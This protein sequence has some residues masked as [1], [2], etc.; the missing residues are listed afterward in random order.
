ML[1][2]YLGLVVSSTNFGVEGGNV[3]H[4]R[5][6][7][8]IINHVLFIK[9][10]VLI[11]TY[12]KF[13]QDVSSDYTILYHLISFS[14][15]TTKTFITES[16]CV[17]THILEGTLALRTSSLI[18]TFPPSDDPCHGFKFRYIKYLRPNVNAGIHA[19]NQAT[20]AKICIF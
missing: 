11:N 9:M 14:A 17:S 3:L 4:R 13:S 15:K 7:D 5:Y 19:D 16:Q 1:K 20:K 10:I 18:T 6:T 12:W 2:I 8:A